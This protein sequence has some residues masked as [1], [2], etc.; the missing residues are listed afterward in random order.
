MEDMSFADYILSEKSLSKKMEILYYFKKKAE[1]FF[2]NTVIFKTEI[3]RM[4]LDYTKQD[5]DR[6][7]VLTACLLYGC[8]KTAIAF[9]VDKVKTYAKEGS[10]Y[11]ETLGFD[12]RFCK[13]C[14]EVNR[15]EKKEN[16]EKEGD[17][18][19]VIDNF[20]MLL[21]RD[22]RR[23]FTPEEAIFI[24]EHE[25]LKGKK[26]V[27]LE[28]FKE[29]VMEMENIES[30]GLDKSKLITN[31]KNKINELYKYDIVKGMNLANKNR[32]EAR[33]LYIEGKKIE[34]NKDGIR[35]KK[36]EINAQRRLQEE[37]AKQIDK[38]H[39]FSELLDDEN[40]S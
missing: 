11:L 22:D 23:A 9:D 1:I 7:L 27:Y 20:G 28:D 14:L 17:L 30:V 13:I 16:R 37:L 21:D 8:K 24:L 6:N 40:I 34:R 26:N 32:N 4:F 35:D 12:K 38:S 5:V 33:K 36:Q 15:Y 18:L 25:N 31:W 3:C 2:D 39:K 19:E 10:K 29:F